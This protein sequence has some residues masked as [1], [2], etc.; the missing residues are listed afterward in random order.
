MTNTGVVNAVK[1]PIIRVLSFDPGVKGFAYNV[2][3]HRIYRKKY[4]SKIIETG[5]LSNTI[6]AFDETYT[7]NLDMYVKA[8]KTLCD[9]LGP[10]DLFCAERFMARMGR[11]LK[12]VTMEA[13]SQM[14][15]V[16]VW[17]IRQKYPKIK[18]VLVSAATWK[19]AYNRKF[20]PPARAKKGQP[21][22]KRVPTFLEQTYKMCATTPHELDSHLI[23]SFAAQKQFDLV[24]YTDITVESRDKII[25]QVEKAS[26]LTLRK[27]RR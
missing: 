8:V 10:F 6:P 24:P 25:K 16:G 27:I 15:G 11:N 4:Q 7:E 20:T 19:N 1:S 17:I 26:T 23:G 18:V 9:R 21:K 22:P 13:V 12:G 5:I 2:S 3:H 14:L